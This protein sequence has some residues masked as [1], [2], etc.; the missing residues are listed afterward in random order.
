MFICLTIKQ[1]KIIAERLKAKDKT[2][3]ILVDD[4]VF[5]GN[6]LRYIIEAITP[7]EALDKAINAV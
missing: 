5:S 6:L 3:I 7:N 1:I 4:V 2:E